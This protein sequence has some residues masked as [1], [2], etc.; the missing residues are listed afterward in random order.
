MNHAFNRVPE[1]FSDEGQGSTSDDTCTVLGQPGGIS[2]QVGKHVVREVGP[3]VDIA[4]AV[5]FSS[6]GD[7]HD[8][9]TV[10]ARDEFVV[11]PGQFDT[12]Y[13]VDRTGGADD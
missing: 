8:R 2:T 3:V 6:K 5:V 13:R 7:A 9:N 4:R 10:F 1:K 12:G 11:V